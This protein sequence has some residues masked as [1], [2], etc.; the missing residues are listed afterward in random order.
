MYRKA[1][2]GASTSCARRCELIGE[3]GPDAV[4]HR[5]V[6]ERAGLPLSATT[7]W[8]DSKEELLQETLLLAA[9]EEVERLERLVLDLAPRELDV[10]EWARAVSAVLAADLESDPIRHVAFI[11]LVLEGDAPALAA[12]RRW[13]AGTP[14][15]CA[16]PSWACAP[17]AHRDPRAD[18]PAAGRHDHRLHA[19]PARHARR[20]L[21]GAH[22]PARARAAVHQADRAG[23][24][25]RREPR[26]PRGRARRRAR[27]RCCVHGFPQSSYMWRDVLPVGGRRGLARGSPP[28]WPASATRR[29]TRPARGSARS[30][31]SRRSAPSTAWSAARLVMHDWGGADRPALGVRAP[32]RRRRPRDQL[33]RLLPRRQV[34]RHGQG[35]AHAR[36]RGAGA[37]RPRPGRLRGGAA[38]VQRGLRRRRD[39][40]VLEGARRRRPPPQR[41][42]AVPLGRLRE[43]RRLP[44][45]RPGRAGAA[46]LGRARRVRPAGRRAP[47]RARAARHRAGA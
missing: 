47:L 42:R 8:F 2:L 44:A 19:R 30:R 34:A 32:R 28:T 5:A 11:E 9:R 4:T 35:A 39:R 14:R 12:P 40:R 7:Y 46:R 29:S 24:R 26:L 27:S 36:G 20:R 17:P 37:G 45:G 43:A 6:A 13:R 15:T 16:W 18:A 22:L 23:Y 3:H 25:A 33:G 38:R 31:R 1:R 41:A 10:R 21:R